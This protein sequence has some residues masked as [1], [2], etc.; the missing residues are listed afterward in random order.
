M[1]DLF[2]QLSKLFGQPRSLG[3]IYGLLFISERPLAMDDFIARLNLSKGSASQGLKYLRNMGAIK[4]V[5]LPEARA[6]HY[7]AVAELRK[8]LTG[9]MRDQI[10]PQ[11]DDGATRL[12]RISG[13]VSK[14]P[15]RERTRLQGRMVTLQNWSKRGRKFLPIIVKLLGG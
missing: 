14:M 6:V 8:L 4:T 3:E 2:V 15:S 11:L 12:Q 10:V 7:E 5:T 1:I 13:L 9:F